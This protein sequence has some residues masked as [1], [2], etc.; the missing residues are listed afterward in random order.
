MSPEAIARAI[1]A[2]SAA[3][4]RSAFR[5]PIPLTVVNSEKNPRSVADPNPSSL[6]VNVAP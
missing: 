4:A 2:G 1:S 6:G 3:I 5:E